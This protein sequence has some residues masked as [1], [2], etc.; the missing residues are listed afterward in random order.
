MILFPRILLLALL[1]PALLFG[2]GASLLAAEGDPWQAVPGN[3]VAL[4]GTA[5]TMYAVGR[6]SN[7]WQWQREGG[8]WGRFG[9]QLQRLVVAPSGQ[10]WGIA[11]DG[12]VQQ[13]NGVNWQTLD[14]KARDIAVLQNELIVVLQNGELRKRARVGSSVAKEE[15]T[16]PGTATRIAAARDGSLWKLSENGE[17]SRLTNGDS[18]WKTLPGKARDINVAADGAI[19]MASTQGELMRWEPYANDWRAVPAPQGVALAAA[20]FSNTLWVML[21]NG[22]LQAQGTITTPKVTSSETSANS[23]TLK[24]GT[25]RGSRTS[26]S[27]RRAAMRA[28]A[29]IALNPEFATTDLS[30]FTFTDTR[31]D[32]K[33]LTIGVDGSVFAIGQDDL[34]YQWR[35]AEQRF[36]T[37]P[38][39][40]VKI[41][42]DPSG[43]LWGINLHGRIFQNTG[44]DWEQVTGT[45]SDIAIGANGRVIVAD[46]SGE[47]SEYDPAIL[48]FRVLPGMSAWFVA[49][50]PDGTPWGLL[51]DGNVVRCSQAP[52]ERLP[53]QAISI[54][55]GPDGSVFVVTAEGRLER[56][57]AATGNWEIITVNGLKV[58]DVAVGPKG[59]PWV[60]AA[61]GSVLYSAQFPRDESTDTQSATTTSTP[62]TG[63]G[64]TAPVSDSGSFVINK[65]ISFSSVA[66]G[67][68]SLQAVTV[69]RDGSVLAIGFSDVFQTTPAFEKYNTTTKKLMP[70][71]ITLPNNDKFRTVKADANGELWFLSLT[72]NGRIYHRKSSGSFETVDVF[73]GTTFCVSGFCGVEPSLLD[74]EIA[75]N[76]DL[77]VTVTD[78]TL[79]WRSTQAS[80][81]SKLIAGTFRSVAVTR[82]GDVWVIAQGGSIKQIIDGKAITRALNAGESAVDI[83]GSA[84]GNLF[85][86]YFDGINTKLARWNTS[87]QKFDKVSQTAS[88]VAVA[89]DG[90]PWLVDADSNPGFLFQAK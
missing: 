31:S 66:S 59:R 58:R 42:V 65:N 24:R 8:Y 55:I 7:V 83:A 54:A 27:A 47:L 77:Y 72:T 15:T 28:A 50:A 44:S 76:G 3:A 70:Q 67:L 25:N 17:I 29:F 41:A 53:K 6:D 38:G 69:G 81:F 90:R 14:F 13:H 60:V 1:L 88:A 71:T 4:T 20:G 37:F 45:A 48:G 39:D 36:K 56:Y 35:N 84:D 18:D 75:S 87:S 79:H 34:I 63:S 61:D 68:A 86:S 78:G 23:V 89:P 2:G 85:I 73:S 12:T 49:V 62:T 26:S 33:V 82:S 80:K 5:E 43:S 46:A 52:C 9:G 21:S 22:A 64:D 51:Q 40:L 30:P 57:V 74:L 32:G 10:L 16:L 11:P 19:Y